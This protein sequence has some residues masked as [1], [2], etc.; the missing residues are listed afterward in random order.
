MVS[1][2]EGKIVVYGRKRDTKG[3]AED[4]PSDQCRTKRSMSDTHYKSNDIGFVRSLARLLGSAISFSSPPF[5]SFQAFR[6]CTPPIPL[7]LFSPSLPA[8]SPFFSPIIPLRLP[9]FSIMR[10]FAIFATLL[11]AVTRVAAHGYVLSVAADGHNETGCLP[12]ADP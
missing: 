5:R 10:S 12:F 3:P 9:D 1:E 2:I 11:A 8:K 4:C 6:R 7:G